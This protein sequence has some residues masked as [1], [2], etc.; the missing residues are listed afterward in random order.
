MTEDVPIGLIRLDDT[1]LM[2]AKPE[3]DVRG[4]TVVGSDGEEI[5]KV[6]TLFI[7]ADE[8]RVRL[9]DV[10]SGGLLGMGA[11]HRLIPVDAV[12]EVT[13]EQVTIGKTRSEIASAPGYDP[14]LE[15][16]KPTDD[17]NSLYGY[18]GMTPYWAAGYRYPGYP[19]RLTA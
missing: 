15:E 18:Y 13:A 19:F 3:D 8:R 12:V 1:D 17:L 10:A 4:T 14:D 16:F 5:G 11:E 9:L 7:D 6:S 2:L